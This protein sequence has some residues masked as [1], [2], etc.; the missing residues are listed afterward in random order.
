MTDREQFEL[1]QF[2]GTV[3]T[4]LCAMHEDLTEIKERLPEFDKRLNVVERSQ[5]RIKVIVGLI[6]AF[7][8]V[9]GGIFGG[10]FGALVTSWFKN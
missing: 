6:G 9:L 1:G 3:L 10:K 8:G 4:K 7:L 5:D 2:K